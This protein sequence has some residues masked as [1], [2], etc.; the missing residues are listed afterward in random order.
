MFILQH[1]ATSQ[2]GHKVGPRVHGAETGN[3]PTRADGG[4]HVHGAAPDK[5][6]NAEHMDTTLNS[7]WPFPDT[8]LHRL[9]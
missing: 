2:H 9:L 1:P 4:P 6:L 8:N 7:I 3:Q 5:L